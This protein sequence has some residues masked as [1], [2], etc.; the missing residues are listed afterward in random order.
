MNTIMD[1][2][3]NAVTASWVVMTFPYIEHQD[4]W[5]TWH[6][7]WN[8]SPAPVQNV[9]LRL[10]VCPSNPTDQTTVGA[11]PLAYC[12]NTGIADGTTTTPFNT[13]AANTT[14]SGLRTS[15]TE[16]K[17]DG[18]FFDN[19]TAAAPAYTSPTNSANSLGAYAVNAASSGRTMS[20]DYL[21]QHDGSSN[22]LM[23]GEN[24]QNITNSVCWGSVIASGVTIDY[25]ES[26]LGFQWD[27]ST[28]SPPTYKINSALMGAVGGAAMPPSSRHGSGVVVSY[29]DGHQDFLRDD[30]N[31]T[32][33]EHLMTPDSSLS[34]IPGVF[35]PASL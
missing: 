29:C 15:G 10:F 7:P 12:V 26:H 11:T 30:I 35:D 1:S 24:I 31:F 4:L 23:L 22:T 21:S 14:T 19:R 18:V 9:Y 2:S 5:K 13:T 32:T 17:S 34:G 3:N 28:T 25:A 33:Y 27:A 6:T 8:A 16:L 20:E